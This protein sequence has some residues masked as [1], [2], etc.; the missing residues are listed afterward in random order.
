MSAE[1]TFALIAIIALLL[2]L[3]LGWWLG[4]RPVADARQE[5][6]EAEAKAEALSEKFNA[7]IR[8][9]AAASE[10]AQ[11]SDEL[12]N[13][14]EALRTEREMLMA[15]NAALKADAVNHDKQ[16]RQLI[17]A[18]E[19]LSA[20]FSEVG[21]KL[22]GEAQKAFLEN[23]DR[24]FAQSEEKSEARLKTL[25]DPVG[26][27]L[28][29]YEESVRKIE[30]E[31]KAA[32]SG[33]LATIEQVRMGQERVQAEASR[34]VNSLRNAPKARGRWGEQQLRNVLESCGL[35]EHT[36]FRMEASV[37]TDDGRLRPDAIIRVPGGQS[38]VVDAK[39]SLNAYQDAFSADD[40]DSRKIA[41]AS[42]CQSMRTHI[43]GLSRKAY[44]DQFEDAPDY[45][46]MFV[47]GEHFLAAA[48]E[49]DAALWDHA[50]DKKVLLATPTNL[51]AIARTVASVWRQEGLEREAKQIGALG[52]EMYDRLAVSAEHLKR[53]GAGL[54]NAVGNY[55]RFVGSFERNVLS[56]GRRFA[57]L[58]IETG[59]RELEEVPMVDI[60]PRYGQNETDEQ[61][62]GDPTDSDMQDAAE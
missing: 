25:L 51:V 36:D 4:G 11:R 15:D 10:R 8:D 62:S 48:L 34:L 47:P 7:A 61:S 2:G 9:L 40:D 38:L 46:I 59:K 18:R 55:N 30:D 52:K 56:T 53:M 37:D 5:R 45:V 26:E 29:A 1:M 22:L 19:A 14:L 21:G 33:V 44:W 39:V 24:R 17:E 35:A 58:N 27:K 13:R 32:Y 41:L 20:Q 31:R 28:R 43:D 49:H 54:N 16:L 6:E 57:E 3:G 50:F 60:L 42:H 23:A 12:A